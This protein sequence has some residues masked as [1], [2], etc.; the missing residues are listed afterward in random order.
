MD[1]K[2]NQGDKKKIIHIVQAPFTCKD[3]VFD[4]V[5][6]QKVHGNEHV[7]KTLYKYKN[8]FE[9]GAKSKK[10]VQC[11]KTLAKKRKIQK[12]VLCDKLVTNMKPHLLL[13]SGKKLPSQRKLHKCK[14]CG[15]SFAN[16]KPHML[17]HSGKTLPIPRKL[18]SCDICK[19]SF[20][21][22]SIHKRVHSGEKPYVC[23]ICNKSFSQCGSLSKHHLVHSMKKGPSA[24]FRKQLAEGIKNQ[25]VLR[26]Q[27]FQ[28]EM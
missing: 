26:K 9:T 10:V 24:V 25:A 4:E 16:L 5:Y 8:E 14:I 13:H 6:N 7:H 23:N 15:K 28:L 11:H 18:H 27:L 2:E 1:S 21:H 17:V 19:K 20:T 22:L 12:C 3:E